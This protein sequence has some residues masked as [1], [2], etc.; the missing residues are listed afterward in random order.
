[1]E[2]ELRQVKAEKASALSDLATTRE[3]CVKLDSGKEFINRQLHAKTQDVEKVCY[4][5]EYK[6]KYVWARHRFLLRT[7]FCVYKQWS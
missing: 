3:L 7:M 6:L 4:P 5:V 2:E 1:M